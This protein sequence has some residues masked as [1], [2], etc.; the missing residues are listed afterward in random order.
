MSVIYLQTKDVAH[1]AVWTPDRE[2]PSAWTS[3]S[4]RPICKRCLRVAEQI[5]QASKEIEP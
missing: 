2:Q 5:N 3:R 1:I 4:H